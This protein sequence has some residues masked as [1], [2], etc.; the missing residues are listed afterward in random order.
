MMVDIVS[1]LIITYLAANVSA[2]LR[3]AGVID[4]YMLTTSN[5]MNQSFSLESK[6]ENQSITAF[7]FFHC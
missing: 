2:F 1:S 6:F 7:E 5:C 4:P 3:I